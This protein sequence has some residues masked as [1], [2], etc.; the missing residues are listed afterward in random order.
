MYNKDNVIKEKTYDFS[1]RIINLYKYLYND[2]KEYVLSKQILRCGTSIG[3]NVEEAVGAISK[4]DFLNKLYIAHKESRETSYWIRLLCD[5]KYIEEKSAKS[6]LKDCNEIIK[7]TGKIIAT[8]N[9]HLR[10]DK[11]KSI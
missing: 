5:T 9:K 4:R 3:A 6:L 1:K 8:T 10:E 11:S 7:I 2:K